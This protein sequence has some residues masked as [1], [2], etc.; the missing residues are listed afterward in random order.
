MNGQVEVKSLI[1]RMLDV[2]SHISCVGVRIYNFCHMVGNGEISAERALLSMVQDY[3]QNREHLQELRAINDDLEK[4]EEKLSEKLYPVVA[5]L[6]KS[7]KNEKLADM[8]RA[9][10]VDCGFSVIPCA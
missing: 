4:F 7:E 5:E 6:R 1:Q 9:A 3:K 2:Q 8:I 10:L